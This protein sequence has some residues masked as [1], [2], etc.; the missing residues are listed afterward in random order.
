M[1]TPKRSRVWCARS[2]YF[3]V[4]KISSHKQN[5]IALFEFCNLFRRGIMGM[6]FVLQITRSEPLLVHME[7]ICCCGLL[8]RTTKVWNPVKLKKN[9]KQICHSFY[10][11]RFTF[12]TTKY[13]LRVRHDRESSGVLFPTALQSSLPTNCRTKEGIFLPQSPRENE[14]RT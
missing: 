4:I 6:I 1:S 14:I 10:Q 7:L 12:M 13:S 5:L 3:V 11:K 9:C 8:V 2:G